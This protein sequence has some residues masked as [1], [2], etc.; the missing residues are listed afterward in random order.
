VKPD[1]ITATIEGGSLVLRITWPAGVPQEEKD[2][3]LN[4]LLDR[5]KAAYRVITEGK[6]ELA[7]GPVVEED[8]E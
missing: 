2:R 3:F 1:D 4:D 5:T 6:D 8:V 7:V